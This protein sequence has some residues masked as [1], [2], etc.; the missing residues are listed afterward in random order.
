MTL[1]EIQGKLGRL[2][3]PKR[4]QKT[5]GLLHNG[6]TTAV[7]GDQFLGI[8]MMA[9][10]KLSKEYNRL[11]FKILQKLLTSKIHEERLLS[12]LILVNHYTIKE[13][14]EKT[15]ERIYKFYT[16]HLKWVNNWDLVDISADKI[17]G[18]YLE[19]KPRAILSQWAQSRDL[20]ERSISIVS[21]L[22]YVRQK[23]FDD[24]LKIAGLLMGD[25][26]DLIHKAVGEM[27]S[28]VGKRDQTAQEKFLNKYYKKMPATMLR[29]AVEKLPTSKQKKYTN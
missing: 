22:H 17:V 10:R 27:L 25:N 24:A 3:N 8:S 18:A 9:L 28:E 7:A 5:K 29:T 1:Q 21:T 26:S 11:D 4:A 23:K 20:W 2:A 16:R 13:T 12:L 15:K 6:E 14:D 19:D